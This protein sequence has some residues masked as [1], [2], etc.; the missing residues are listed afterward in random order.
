MIEV[1]GR[2]GITKSVGMLALCLG[3]VVALYLA[4]ALIR[5]NFSSPRII[6]KINDS[7]QF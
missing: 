7:G 1:G 4:M 2:N 3:L 5:N 6:E